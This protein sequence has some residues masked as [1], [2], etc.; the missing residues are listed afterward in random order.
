MKRF[1]HC[2][3]V[4]VSV[5]RLDW[6]GE[7]WNRIA[8]SVIPI[9]LFASLWPQKCC[10][11]CVTVRLEKHKCTSAK[12]HKCF[13]GTEIVWNTRGG[14]C[15]GR[16]TGWNTGVW[17]E[18]IWTLS[19][20][21][22]WK[23]VSLIQRHNTNRDRNFFKGPVSYRRCNFLRNVYCL[24]VLRMLKVPKI[25]LITS[26]RYG[27]LWMWSLFKDSVT[28]YTVGRQDRK[29]R[30]LIQNHSFT[31]NYCLSELKRGTSQK[32]SFVEHSV[33][34][35][36]RWENYLCLLVKLLVLLALVLWY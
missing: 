10:E 26:G 29:F 25:A 6:E 32:V 21:S 11:Q 27:R 34:S 30:A 12:V 33:S 20:Y 28:T 16:S 24:C 19:V 13:S 14:M 15:S 8:H 4:H 1:T 23:C 9:Q 35:L 3:P 17:N 7:V 2:P 18:S 5:T 31:V 22:L 36:R